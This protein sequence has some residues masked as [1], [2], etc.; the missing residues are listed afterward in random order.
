[1]VSPIDRAYGWQ[2][3]WHHQ[4]IDF[5]RWQTQAFRR[6]EGQTRTDAQNLCDFLDSIDRRISDTNDWVVGR[7]YLHERWTGERV[8]K[9]GG[10]TLA[11][12]LVEHRK[13]K[14]R[15][16][17]TQRN[18][19]FNVSSHLGDWLSLPITA[20][21]T[22]MIYQRWDTLLVE[23]KLAEPTAR[24]IMSHIIP[25]LRLAHRKGL[26]SVDPVARDDHGA[27]FAQAIGKDY[28]DDEPL[29]Q[30]E[31][32]KLLTQAE[33]FTPV[34]SFARWRHPFSI[35][36]EL[37]MN[38]EIMGECGLRIGEV[39]A[40]AVEDADLDEN[41]LHVDHHMVG[42]KREPG[43]KA[44]KDATRVVAIPAGLSARLRLFVEGRRQAL[45]LLPTV[46]DRF[47]VYGYWHPDIW[48][49]FADQVAEAGFLRSKVNL[50][51]HL[52]RH[53]YAT[54][55][56]PHVSAIV[57]MQMLGHANLSTTQRYYTRVREAVE[58]ARAAREGWHHRGGQGHITST[59]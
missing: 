40:L 52:L 2:V 50:I 6:E 36:E 30:G 20:I 59:S 16:D 15:S 27:Y 1:M 14:H 55:T 11:E 49:P 56:A 48:R 22:E 5:G 42:A 54:W 33:Q 3:K 39:N 37:R 17:A 35:Q 23:K 53:S 29:R 26:L 28:S 9:L 43:T 10:M 44:G 57:L 7:R 21:T 25:A 34:R 13:T 24:K 45:P 12:L 18:I 4:D 51:P 41:I 46:Y 38:I 31:Y 47:F 58:V 32:Y 8:L 19:D